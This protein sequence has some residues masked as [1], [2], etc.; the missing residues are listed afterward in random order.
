MDSGTSKNATEESGSSRPH[1]SP[2]GGINSPT[3]DKKSEG[4]GVSGNNNVV[5]HGNASASGGGV[6]NYGKISKIY[7]ASTPVEDVSELDKWLKPVD[8]TDKMDLYLKN[9]V[10]GTRQSLLKEIIG[11]IEDANSGA[12]LWI[13]GEA[14]VGKSMLSW[15]V[16]NNIP[17]SIV[18]GAM[19]FCEFNNVNRSRADQV[20]LTVAAKLAKKIPEYAEFLAKKRNQDSVSEKKLLQE[21]D[22][23]KLFDEL[24]LEG[25]RGITFDKTIVIII[26]A[27]DECTLCIGKHDTYQNLLDLLARLSGD[28]KLTFLKIIVSARP[29]NA[30]FERLRNCA[31]VDIQSSKSSR[32]NFDDIV[33]FVSGC[34]RR[35]FGTNDNR[36]SQTSRELARKAEG[37]FLYARLACDQISSQL[38]KRFDK[39]AEMQVVEDI[40][41]N[42]KY[43]VDNLY[44]IELLNVIKMSQNGEL[45]GCEDFNSIENILGIIC[46]VR[47]PLSQVGIADLLDCRER[48]VEAVVNAL[49]KI[50][51]IGK[52]VTVVHKSL[53]DY[54]TRSQSNTPLTIGLNIETTLAIRSLQVLNQELKFN[55]LDLPQ[56]D[57]YRWHQDIPDFEQRVNSIP[58]HLRYAGLY[59]TSHLALVK[60]APTGIIETIDEIVS[61]KLLYWMEL[62]SVLSQFS[63]FVG[64]SA[65]LLAWCS[66]NNGLSK[67]LTLR[68]LSDAKRVCAQFGVPISV[69][70]LQV[71]WS[72]LPFSPV[73]STF[74]QTFASAKWRP[75]GKY[76]ALLQ[77]QGIAT[78]WSPCLCTCVGHTKYVTAVAISNDGDRIVSG[79][80]DNTVKIWN[81]NTR[82]R[83]TNVDRSHWECDCSCDKQ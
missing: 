62:L 69:C 29:E 36:L 81:A 43:G 78:Q 19:F 31:I 63:D 3:P 52:V 10:P 71:Y 64:V 60:E 48:A 49:R 7:I 83:N 18:L 72:A 45:E 35:K 22:I 23:S 82:K 54:L 57:L 27:L 17:E 30:I 6:V 34:L 37:V 2:T 33:K 73:N 56:D 25:L 74:H 4:S 58:D 75:K 20:I 59:A 50:L 44:E 46:C 42:L 77:T 24:I 51:N 53:S 76:P 38:S 66:R 16:S 40:V 79:S 47:E 12:V 70:A 80:G 11:W 5:H 15:I 32:E 8:F 41:R 39:A 68:L 67:T 65:A 55:I 1:Q 14:G 26:D 21:T 9:F 61:T 28:S 13:K